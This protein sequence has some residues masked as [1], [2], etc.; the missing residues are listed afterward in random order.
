M[1]LPV[2]SFITELTQ[3]S[4]RTQ[5]MF[6]LEITSGYSDVD[7]II[8]NITM[9]G[10]NFQ[11]PGRTQ[12]FAEV[13]FKGYAVPIPTNI[14]ME[15]EHTMT[16]NADVNG[17]LRRAFML[18]QHKVS[19]MAISQ[20]T[21]LGGDKRLAANSLIRINLLDYNMEVPVEV[22]KLW[23]VKIQN[24]GPLQMSNVGADVAT[25]DVTFKS[26]Y[27]EVEEVKDNGQGPTPLVTDVK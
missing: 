23:G 25:F 24:V 2:N 6:E 9:F 21:Y 16:V 7:E 8:K 26:V 12:N 19:D 1:A 15:Q 5:N 27:W 20:G 10:Q 3:N 4:I 22:Y 14:Q 18:W 13:S 11:I 17:N